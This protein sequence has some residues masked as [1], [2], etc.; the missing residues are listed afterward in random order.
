MEM[1][2]AEARARFSGAAVARLATVSG[3]G[4]PHVV[5]V[6]FVVDGETVYFA[7]DRKPKTTWD[8]KRLRNVREND[9]VAVLVDHYEHD[10]SALWWARADGHAEVWDG[11]DAREAAVALLRGKYRQYREYAPEGP[12]VAIRVERWSGWSW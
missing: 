8:L 4:A 11:G 1:G 9:R 2:S 3:A 10:W 6:T 7:V 12:V 5:P